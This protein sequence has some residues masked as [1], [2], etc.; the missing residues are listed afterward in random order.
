M[1][2]SRKG[3]YW[4]QLQLL[5]HRSSALNESFRC[6]AY[7]REILLCECLQGNRESK[8]RERENC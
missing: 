2:K 6:A 7:Y 4:S 8:V 1:E 5:R 3:N